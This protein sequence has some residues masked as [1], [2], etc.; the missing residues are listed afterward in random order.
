ML[1]L[2]CLPWDVR[3]HSIQYVLHAEVRDLYCIARKWLPDCVFQ[4]PVVM[5]IHLARFAGAGA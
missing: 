3:K 5:H 4:I 2:D 1:L